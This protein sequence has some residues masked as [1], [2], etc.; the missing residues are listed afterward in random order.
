VSLHTEIPCIV[1]CLCLAAVTLGTCWL[2]ALTCPRVPCVVWLFNVHCVLLCCLLSVP[3]CS[4][5]GHLL[6]VGTEELLARVVR[7]MDEVVQVRPVLL[8]PIGY[9]AEL[10]MFG[11]MGERHLAGGPPTCYF[12]KPSGS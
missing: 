8:F 4:D 3:G 2:W 7:Y 9:M 12:G 10:C 5:P 6:A 1:W 11:Y